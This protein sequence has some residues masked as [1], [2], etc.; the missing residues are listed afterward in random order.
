MKFGLFGSAKSAPVDSDIDS[1]AGYN[2]WIQFN[3]EAEKLGYYSTFTVE[4]HFT[5]LGQVS[6]SMSLLTFL[7]AK[8]STIRLGTAVMA[9]P[10]HNPILLAEQASTLDLLSGGRLDFGV[11][12]GYR[13]NE[14]HG[15]DIDMEEAHERYHDCLQIIL[16]CWNQKKKW[17]HKSQYWTFNDVIV[18]PPCTQKPHPP[19][20]MAAGHPDSIK[21]VAQQNCN[22]LLDQFSPV[23]TVIERVKMKNT[24][25]YSLIL[26][27]LVVAAPVTAQQEKPLPTENDY[28]PLLQLPIPEGVVL[29]ASA[30]EMLPGKKLAVASR[31]LH[32][33]I[34]FRL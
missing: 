5:G 9:L 34:L 14:F 23:S 19:I 24:F 17:N 29:E 33:S 26:M 18:E 1:A 4:H 15:F 25:L 8:T 27:I 11:G 16:K 22:L 2:D 31:R 20:W 7:A 3:Q 21:T 13:Y 30:I 12:K 32:V 10:W 6:A 28:Y